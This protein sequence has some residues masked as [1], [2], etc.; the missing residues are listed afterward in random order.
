M[1]TSGIAIGRKISGLVGARPRKRWRTSAKA[2]IVPSTVATERR[3]EG[4]LQ[5]EPTRVAHVGD[6]ARVLPGVERELPARRS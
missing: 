6:A 2:I 4:D 5:A 1:T 3:Q